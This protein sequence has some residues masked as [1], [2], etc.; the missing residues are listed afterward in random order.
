MESQRASDE[1]KKKA[2]AST[3]TRK[4]TEFNNVKVR[5]GIHGRPLSRI[6]LVGGATRMPA[7]GRLLSTLTGVV[8]QRTVNPDEAVAL[9]CAVQVG[10]LDGTGG[11][12]G[13]QVL[14]PWQ[15]ALIRG[16][17]KKRGLEV[18]E[19]E[20][21]EEDALDEEFG[22]ACSCKYSK[23]TYILRSVSG[24]CLLAAKSDQHSQQATAEA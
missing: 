3:Q 21:G 4:S 22:P 10:V 9:G 11:P 14:T 1:A 13:L 2:S 6:V 19:E 12:G 8:P 20:R 18:E 23:P 16:L 15:A 7:V 5:S 24:K 17:A